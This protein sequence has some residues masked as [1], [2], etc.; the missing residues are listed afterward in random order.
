MIILEVLDLGDGMKKYFSLL[1]AVL[2]AIGIT[3][4]AAPR[5]QACVV[6]TTK[7]VYD[8]TARLCQG[9][10]IQVTQLI[11]EPVSCLHDYSLSISQA[12]KA[13]AAEVTIISGAG[14]EEF[15]EELLRGTIIDSSSNVPLLDCSHEHEHEHEHDHHHQVDN[16]IWLDPEN[17]K[18]MATNICEGLCATYPTHATALRANLSQLLNDLDRLQAYA[19]EQ[20]AD[21]SCREL[22]T[23]HDGFGYLAHAFDLEVAAAVEEESGSEASAKELIEL[24]DLVRHHQIPAVFCETNG[25][26]SAPG[27]IAA[28]TG[29]SVHTLDMAMGERDYFE[30]MYRNIDVLKEALG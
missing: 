18:I 30:S 20:L 19:K 22:I 28:E 16:H 14:L 12:R 21:L 17:A 13:E 10:D 25:S 29:I 7:P 23:F 27:I 11:S 2:L 6:A 3:G 9:T 1:F 26:V 5:E 8:F 4:C 24:I 15:M